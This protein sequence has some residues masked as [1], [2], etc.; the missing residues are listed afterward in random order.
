MISK[1]YDL[2]DKSESELKYKLEAEKYIKKID[3]DTFEQPDGSR[4]SSME[5][6]LNNMWRLKKKL[7]Q[8]PTGSVSRDSNNI[9]FQQANAQFRIKSGQRIIEAL[10]DFIKNPNKGVTAIIH[11]FMHPTVVE[12]FNG[13]KNGNKVG[14]NAASSR[15]VKSDDE[16]VRGTRTGVNRNK[17][18][19]TSSCQIG[20]GM[21]ARGNDQ[22]RSKWAGKEDTWLH[23]DGLKSA[24]VVIKMASGIPTSEEL[25]M[26]ATILA[27]FSHFQGDC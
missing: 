23:L 16:Y 9:L 26:G 15:L 1:K 22:L 7:P 27:H 13:A 12:I 14:G 6:A 5:S 3:D 10:K 11:E 19:A 20:V 25:N 18:F 8:I 2:S 4:F 17:I 21:S 24:H